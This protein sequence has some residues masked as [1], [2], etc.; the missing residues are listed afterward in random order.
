MKRKKVLNTLKSK[1][2]DVVLLQETHLSELQ[3][4]KLRGHWVGQIFYSVGSSS[5]KGVSIL[6]H[7]HLQ[8][9]SKRII[10]D[11]SGGMVI[12]EADIQGHSMVLAN[13]YVP[14]LDFPI[15]SLFFFLV[16]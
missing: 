11:D 2:Y 15:P 13:I 6:V 16:C 5:S 10:T 9:K 14:N 7:E 8:F 1:K 4:K 12:V 3:K